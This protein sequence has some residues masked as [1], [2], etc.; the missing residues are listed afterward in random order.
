VCVY[1]YIYISYIL[2]KYYGAV[3][4]PVAVWSKA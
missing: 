4:V 2:K 3:L 1:I